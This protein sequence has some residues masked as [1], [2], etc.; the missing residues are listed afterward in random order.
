[1]NL[2]PSLWRPKTSVCPPAPS[3]LRTP[4]AAVTAASAPSLTP[5]PQGAFILWTRPCLP[6]KASPRPSSPPARCPPPKST[7]L[8]LRFL[9]LGL[10]VTY[11][12]HTGMVCPLITTEANVSPQVSKR[13]APPRTPWP[14]PSTSLALCPL[15]VTTGSHNLLIRREAPPRAP[16]P[17]TSPLDPPLS[18][19]RPIC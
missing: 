6:A 4:V 14:S 10:K 13:E 3:P 11:S 5:T 9:E 1:M 17:L 19:P 8:N 12:A 15:L 2:R 18:T 7:E 16:R